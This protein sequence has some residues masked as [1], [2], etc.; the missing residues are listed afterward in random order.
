MK[1]SKFK[2]FLPFSILI[3]LFS[4]YSQQ[5]IGQNTNIKFTPLKPLIYGKGSVLVE[6]AL[7]SQSSLSFEYQRWNQNRS[8]N[9]NES[10]WLL[11]LGWLDILAGSSIHYKNEGH[12]LGLEYRKYTEENT[13]ANTGF[14]WTLGAYY[15][16][17]KVRIETYSDGLFSSGRRK[18]SQ[19]ESGH[20]YGTKG[21]CGIQK[22]FNWFVLDWNTKIGVNNTNMEF[23]LNHPA[24]MQGL[25]IESNLSIGVTF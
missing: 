19:S 3:F 5:S 13:N 10:A 11:G 7:S 2:H 4:I 23:D 15:G 6:H 12:R 8:D 24:T 14:Y 22:K 18:S 9:T 25:S 17:H 16:M 1:N 20:S 21:G